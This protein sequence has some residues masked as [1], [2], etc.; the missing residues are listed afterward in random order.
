M[1]VVGVAQVFDTGTEED[2]H[3]TQQAGRLI[4]SC[5]FL[6][7][8]AV[9]EVRSRFCGALDLVGNLYVALYLAL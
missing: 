2:S 4:S 1:F 8:P 7:G 9:V 5:M 3:S 6:L